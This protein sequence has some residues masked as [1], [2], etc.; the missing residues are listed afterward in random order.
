MP[1]RFEVDPLKQEDDVGV[2]RFGFKFSTNVTT[3][4]HGRDRQFYWKA[5]LKLTGVPQGAEHVKEARSHSFQLLPRPPEDKLARTGHRLKLE[6]VVTD[7]RPDDL[8]T[9]LGD[10]FDESHVYALFGQGNEP[11][12]RLHRVRQI[13]AY[14]CRIPHEVEAGRYW[15]Q[16]HSTEPNIEANQG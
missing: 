4:Q 16:M 2:V 10:R 5:D 9:C 3:R 6:C 12:T 11:G 1:I 8:V 13:K 7:G 15:I 14:V